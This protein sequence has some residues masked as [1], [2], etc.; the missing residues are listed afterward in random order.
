MDALVVGAG[1]SGLSSAIRLQQAGFAV[2]VRA[3]ARTPRTTSDVAAAYYFP[4]RA[5]PPHRVVAWSR[6][7]LAQL[8]R[9]LADPASGVLPGR[10]VQL[11]DKPTPRPWWADAVDGFR[12]ARADELPPGYQAGW[13][14]DAPVIQ[15]PTYLPFLERRFVAG[16]GR[17]ED[18]HVDDVRALAQQEARLVVNCT[19]L[20]A[21]DAAKDPEVFPIRGQVVRVENPGLDVI[22]NDADGPRAL[23][24]VVPRRDGVVLGGTSQDGDW[25][26]EPDP[27]TEATILRRCREIEP[28]LANAKVLGRAVG[29]RPGRGEVRL[30][31]EGNLIHNYGHGGAGVTLSW[32][33]ADEVAALARR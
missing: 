16:G 4:Y 30:E 24:Y 26:L 32:G 9:L 2:T 7:T 13:V 6:A 22:W 15:M 1:V 5:K 33:C 14:A 18:G 3:A 31:R 17:F 11:Y 28:R 10:V 29:L 25:S 23:S 19:G 21:R 20:G 12:A 8:R 27:A